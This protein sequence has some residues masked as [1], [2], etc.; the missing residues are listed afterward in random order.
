MYPFSIIDKKENILRFHNTD[1]MTDSQLYISLQWQLM[2]KILSYLIY[3]YGIAF[4]IHM[5]REQDN[6][7]I[8][9]RILHT[10]NIKGLLSRY[11]FA[12]VSIFKYYEIF[13][14]NDVLF[15][16]ISD[17]VAYS[18]TRIESKNLENRIG[19]IFE[20][21]NEIIQLL[22]LVFRDCTHIGISNIESYIQQVTSINSNSHR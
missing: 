14:K 7:T 20:K 13:S 2:D 4:I 3:K 17:L 12:E 8:E 16:S 9:K 22:S 6:V 10:E 21:D 5:L 19:E 1:N 15:S 11:P 18:T